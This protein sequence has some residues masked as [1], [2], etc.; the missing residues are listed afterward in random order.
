M[1]GCERGV[2]K[3][4][5]E[6]V[7]VCRHSSVEL[8]VRY[9]SRCLLPVFLRFFNS[10]TLLIH[11]PLLIP[12]EHFELSLFTPSHRR[13]LILFRC[14]TS[15][16]S[17]R[18]L[19]PHSHSTT[20]Q[21]LLFFFLPREWAFPRVVSSICTFCQSLHLLAIPPEPYYGTRTKRL[22]TSKNVC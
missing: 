13:N 17:P 15:S 5:R 7:G 9:L 14:S 10:H 2:H 16:S 18:S 3:G 6:G 1:R 4:V 11:L 19:I 20:P 22:V 8:R 12:S 21:R